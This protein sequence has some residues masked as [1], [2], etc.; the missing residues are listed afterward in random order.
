MQRV[1]GDSPAIGKKGIVMAGFA[2]A[3]YAFFNC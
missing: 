1:N 3:I 2:P